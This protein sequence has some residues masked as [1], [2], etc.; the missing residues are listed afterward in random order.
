M[1]TAFHKMHGLG[2][3]FVILD[4]R[5]APLPLP[6]SRVWQRWRIA[7]AGSDATSL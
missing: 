7:G 3:D 5:P 6:P 1:L 2:N 4:E